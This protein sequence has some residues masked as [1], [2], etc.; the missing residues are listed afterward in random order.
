MSAREGER[1]T[2]FP[3]RSTSLPGQLRQNQIKQGKPGFKNYQS[4]GPKGEKM[5]KML[6]TL[7]VSFLYL[8]TGSARWRNDD[9]SPVNDSYRPFIDDPSFYV[10]T[11]SDGNSGETPTLPIDQKSTHDDEED[12]SN[13]TSKRQKY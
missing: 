13:W 1:V 8:Q 12:T 9:Q 10:T 3:P 6:T 4:R 11:S 5:K 7:S 2:R